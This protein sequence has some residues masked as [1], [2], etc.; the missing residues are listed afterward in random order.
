MGAYIFIKF[1]SPKLYIR[2]C[3]ASN[4]QL[5]KI[6]SSYIWRCNFVRVLHSQLHGCMLRSEWSERRNERYGHGSLCSSYNQISPNNSQP[7]STTIKGLNSHGMLPKKKKKKDERAKERLSFK[8]KKK[9]WK[10][11]VRVS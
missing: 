7:Q 2:A 1:C 4:C 5:V 11:I 8:F 9:I 6:C 3:L 10:K